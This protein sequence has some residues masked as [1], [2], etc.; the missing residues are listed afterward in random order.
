MKF[1]NCI[2]STYYATLFT[3]HCIYQVVTVSKGEQL[4]HYHCT[5]Y[6]K[7]TFF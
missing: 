2:V 3:I 6:T 4:L 5:S 7:C 1:Y